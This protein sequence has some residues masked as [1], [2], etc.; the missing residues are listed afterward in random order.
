M[1]KDLCPVCK[2]PLALYARIT[3]EGKTVC[4]KC[5]TVLEDVAID[6]GP[7]WRSF[8][9]E[10]RVKKSRVGAPTTKR[11]HNGGI[12][13]VIYGTARNP[14]AER[15]RKLHSRMRAMENKELQDILRDYVNPMISEL[16]LPR[17]VAETFAGIVRR[18][19]KLGEVDGKSKILRKNNMHEYLLAAAIIASKI[20]NHPL[21]IKD[22]ARIYGVKEIAIWRAYRVIKSKLHIRIHTLPKPEQYVP[23]IASKL[24]LEGEVETLAVRLARELH[25]TRLDQGKPPE[26]IAAAAVYLASILLNKKKNQLVVAKTINVTDATIRNRY[27]DIVDNLHIEVSL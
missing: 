20:N 12:G 2:H 13:S 21:T 22:V 9:E 10:D 4:T 18:L 1:S 14:D 3:S 17:E 8:T 6:Y 15:L 19:V 5:A 16:R 27:R 25:K 7:E 11:M 23:R 26:A 24:N